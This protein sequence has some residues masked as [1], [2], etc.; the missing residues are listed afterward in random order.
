MLQLLTTLGPKQQSELG[1]I[2]PHEHIFVDLGPKEERN[3]ERAE[4]AEVVRM[5]A[6]EL[7]K[8]RAAGGD[9]LGRKHAGRGRA[10]RRHRQ[11]GFR[12]EY[13]SRGRSHR[14]LPRTLGA[15]V[16]S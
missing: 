13:L 16:G 12:S 7:E 2:L 6:P 8:A 1:M 10:A 4:A 3:Y 9:G 11:G 15:G 14:H 5:M